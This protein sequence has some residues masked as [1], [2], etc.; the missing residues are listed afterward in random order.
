MRQRDRLH[1]SAVISQLRQTGKRWHH[2]LAALFVHSNDQEISRFGFSASRRVGKAVARNRAKRL[3]REAVRL[4]LGE[5]QPGWDCLLVART[6]TAE[7]TFAEVE[8]AVL[9]LLQRGR[10]L[11]AEAERAKLPGEQAAIAATQEAGA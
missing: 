7:A 4:H 9:Q 1:G 8:T 11:I 3:L 10:L 5:V 2:P 6:A